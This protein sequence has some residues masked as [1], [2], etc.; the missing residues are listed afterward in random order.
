MLKNIWKMFLFFKINYLAKQKL[1]IR[2]EFILL[3]LY[4]LVYNKPLCL[5]NFPIP[6]R[7]FDNYSIYLPLWPIQSFT[8]M[9]KIIINNIN[10]FFVFLWSPNGEEKYSAVTQFEATDARRCFPCWDEPAIKAEFDILLSVPQNK[11]ALSNM[12]I[13]IF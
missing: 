10:D 7:I 4:W 13:Y 5:T 9:I 8:N 6:G 1:A 2:V 11:I 12:V 3:L